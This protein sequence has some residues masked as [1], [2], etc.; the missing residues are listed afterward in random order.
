LVHFAH[1]RT[2]GRVILTKNVRDFEILHNQHPDH[3]GIL[4]VYQ[5]NDPARDMSY[6][7]I[8]QAIANLESAG[9]AIVGGFWPLNAYRW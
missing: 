6:S 4:V 9:V 2:N 3:P 8:I 1:A 5:D 7:E